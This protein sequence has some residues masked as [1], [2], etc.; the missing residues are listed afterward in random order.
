MPSL[1][2]PAPEAGPPCRLIAFYLPQFHP[3]PENDAWWGEGFT[4]W[5]HVVRAR[6][7]WDGH[8]Q[9]REPGPLGYYDLRD[10]AVARAQIRLARA[11]GIHGFCYHTYWFGGR[12]L[13]EGPLERVLADPSLDLPFCVCWANENWTRRWDGLE[14]EVLIAQKHSS[15]DDLA[16]L[17]AMAPLLRDPRYI[18]VRGRPLLVVYRPELLPR[19]RATAERWRRHARKL[20]IEEPYLVN[21][22]S[23]PGLVD[24]RPIGFDASVEFPPHQNPLRDVSAEVRALDPGFKGHIFDYRAC[25]RE[26][27]ARLSRSWPYPLFPAVMPR[28][29]NTPR[30]RQAG[31]A[32]VHADPDAYQ[33]WL[34]AACRRAARRADPEER[35]VFINAWNEWGEGAYLEPDARWGTAYLEATR[36]AL[37]DAAV[38]EHA[39]P[40]SRVVSVVV[41]AYNHETFVGEALESVRRQSLAP[42]EVLVVDDGSTDATARIVEDAAS[43]EWTLLRQPNMGA[44]AALNRAIAR[45]RGPWIAI[46]NS[47]DTFLPTHLERALGVAHA[48][49][50]ALV[51]GGVRLVDASGA[52]LPPEHPTSRW[53]REALAPVPGG[54][55]LA[56]A[57]RRHNLAVTTSNFFIHKELWRRLGG[58][59][60]YRYVHDLDFLLRALDA[61]PDRVVF[62][63]TLEGVAYRVHGANTITE[64]VDRALAERASMLRRHDRAPARLRARLARPLAERALA[65]ALGDGGGLTPPPPP[66]D[67]DRARRTA[68]GSLRCGLVVG[69]LDAGGLEEVVALLALE[70][71]AQGVEPHVVCTEAGGRIARRLVRAGVPVTVA[72]S[73]VARRRWLRAARPDVL[74]THFTPLHV[75]AELA[76][77]GVPLVETVHNAYAWFSADDWLRE[78]EKQRWLRAVVA[79]SEGA[80]AYYRRR[81]DGASA[82]LS[83]IPN[84]VAPDR[85][86]AVPRPFARRVLGLP[87]EAPVLVQ[88][89]RI[90][91]QKNQLGALAAFREIEAD[92]PG[93]VLV[94]AGAEADEAYAA[95]LRRETAGLLEAKRVRILPPRPD[96]GTLLSAAD[97]YVSHSWF[98]GWSLSASE[99]LWTGL[100]LVVSDT[101]GSREMVG[102][103][104]ARGSL[105]PNPLGDPLDL[106]PAALA[107]ATAAPN[108]DPARL[109]SALDEVLR[110]R[111]TWAERR[112]GILAWARAHLPACRVAADYAA[113]LRNLPS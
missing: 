111:A 44:H 55:A 18:R 66:A 108:A 68:S 78:R 67:V 12:R 110:G 14:K 64:D 7:S 4:E 84:G 33:R 13:L 98:E 41:P 77:A 60:P 52:P 95:R 1:P 69:T 96:V 42:A 63:P 27:E 81:M 47:D 26:G 112:P 43:P 23:V 70:L 17:E 73:P 29:D 54:I 39:A 87:P 57:V 28:W 82:P 88:F 85:A 36:K 22:H 89:G 76:G 25:V 31:T 51:V 92:H 104:G 10:P 46:L 72:R 56:E 45:A 34:T 107:A 61:V 97:A 3:I 32:F 90:E 16:F 74:S 58:F 79:V 80:A 5:T 9:P 109:A 102:E 86:A 59:R 62:E 38:R 65:T 75:A 35:L 30:R 20:G 94:L 71:P 106:D 49:G 6:P 105:V 101:G 15:R 11:H 113:L 21:A 40:A 19:P 103:D 100:P 99:A 37:L 91:P 24:P 2:R 48:T 50:A 8:D 83:I 93:S 53:Y